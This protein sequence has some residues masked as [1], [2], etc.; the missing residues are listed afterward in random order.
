MNAPLQ[1][2]NCKSSGYLSLLNFCAFN[3]ACGNYDDLAHAADIELA[4]NHIESIP[5]DIQPLLPVTYF[6]ALQARIFD[7]LA[8]TAQ[9]F[10]RLNSMRLV[11]GEMI[12]SEWLR[13]TI[14]VFSSAGI[15]FIVLKGS[16]FSGY[17]YREDAPRPGVDIDILVRGHDFD[18]ACDLLA[19]DMEPVVLSQ[20]RLATH[21][22]LF[23]RVFVPRS[24]LGP[25]VEL[26]RGLT[27]PHIF[28][29]EE[30]RLWES[31]EPHPKYKHECARILSPENT[32]LHLAVHAFRDMDFCSHN[33]LDAH[34]LIT[35]RGYDERLLHRMSI[36]WGARAV[37]Y[38]LLSNAS[39]IM[40]SR[41]NPQFLQ[42]LAPVGIRRRLQES[43]LGPPASSKTRYRA[44][45]MLGQLVFP[46]SLVGAL[47]FQLHYTATRL[48]DAAFS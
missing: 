20:S 35:M 13:K 19:N 33:L 18:K 17:L 30:G 16:A 3:P 31:S 25:T 23:E 43:L 28:N 41:V 1:R 5:E 37:L 15:S 38:H 48:K 8:P 12:K 6:N 34:R 4:L 9:T 44:S 22:S 42:V 29:I 47:R 26:H 21:R 45:Q 36:D 27:N 46:D 2:A 11:G 24:G 14:A 10:I 40:G 7:H 39:V 32:L